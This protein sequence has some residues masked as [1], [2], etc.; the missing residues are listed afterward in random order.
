MKIITCASYYGSGSSALTDLVSEYCNVKNLS[1]FEFRFLHDLDGISDLEFQLV[2]CHNRHNAGH[3]IKRFE[4]LMHFNEGNCIS[5]RYSRFFKK[6]DYKRIN[7]EYVESLVEFKYNGW[8]FYDLYD[9]G[10]R[11]YYI[12][13][14]FNHILRKLRI[15]RFRILKNEQTYM[16]HPSENEFLSKT[17]KYVSDMMTALNQ[18]GKEYLEIDQLVPSS[19]IQRIIRYFKDD[20][21]V[22]VVD[23]D[24]RDIYFINKYCWKEFVCPSYDVGSFCKWYRYVREAGNGIPLNLPNV[25]KIQFED[26]I[27]Q[28]E[29]TVSMIEKITGLNRK[30]HRYKFK[31]LNPMISVNNTQVWKNYLTEED[32]KDKKYIEHTLSDYLYDFDFVQNK[33]LVGIPV[34]DK[35]IF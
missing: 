14:I 34:S 15:Q 23:R 25:K 21:Y 28:Y 27:Y 29:D 31:R 20:I 26:L 4:K 30:E 32:Q 18:E 3:A 7:Q 19:N 16:S 9:K 2:E 12:Y 5:A 8:W 10:S 6:D 11:I 1:D 35:K 24:P 33:K 22:F 17:R 13:Q